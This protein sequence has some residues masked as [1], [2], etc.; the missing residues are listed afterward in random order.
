MAGGYDVEVGNE[1][2]RPLWLV[3]GKVV[4]INGETPGPLYKGGDLLPLRL[5]RKGQSVVLPQLYLQW[6]LLRIL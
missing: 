2:C 5:S 3:G 1:V 4:G 6:C